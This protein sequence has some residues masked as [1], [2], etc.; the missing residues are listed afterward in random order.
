MKLIVFIFTGVGILNAL[1]CYC[2]LCV[3]SEEDRWL[4]EHITCTDEIDQKHTETL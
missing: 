4:E 1:F 3:A 2:A